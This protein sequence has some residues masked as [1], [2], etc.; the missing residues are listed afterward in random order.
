MSEKF[1]KDNVYSSLINYGLPA[2]RSNM[3]AQEAAIGFRERSFPLG[4]VFSTLLAEAK[5]KAGKTVATTERQKKL[6][7][8][9]NSYSD[10]KL[11]K[12]DSNKWTMSSPGIKKSI[13][14]AVDPRTASKFIAAGYFI[15]NS[16]GVFESAFNEA[17]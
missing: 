9:M 7:R 11:I 17:A 3:L 14:E 12:D 10:V 5:K 15:K 2:S 6:L 4:Q 16:D 8:L 13:S 1:I